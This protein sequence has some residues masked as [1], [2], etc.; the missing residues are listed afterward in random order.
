MKRSLD[1]ETAATLYS[2]AGG[3][4][5]ARRE[6]AARGRSGLSALRRDEENL[7]RALAILVP[8]EVPPPVEIPV[9]MSRH[10]QVAQ[11]V[12]VL[13][14]IV[15][16]PPVAGVCDSCIGFGCMHAEGPNGR[17]RRR[18]CPKCLGSG[19]VTE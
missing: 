13:T 9:P 7:K 11:T 18:C 14:P 12:E 8:V 19:H 16:M 1:L 6:Y 10:H 4:K 3:K 5:R 17:T 2:A 15:S